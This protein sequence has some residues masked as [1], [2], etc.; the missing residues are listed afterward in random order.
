MVQLADS[1]DEAKAAFWAGIGAAPLI[2]IG[3]PLLAAIRTRNARCQH[4]Y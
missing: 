1:L 4:F 2:V 3:A